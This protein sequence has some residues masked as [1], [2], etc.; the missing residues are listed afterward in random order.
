M[1]RALLSPVNVDSTVYG[2]EE[3]R[4]QISMYLLTHCDVMYEEIEPLLISYGCSYMRYAY[5]V[6][7]DHVWGDIGRYTVTSVIFSISLSLSSTSNG[8]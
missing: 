4:R 6:Q 2:P 8:T 7:Y 1:F 5:N 3:L